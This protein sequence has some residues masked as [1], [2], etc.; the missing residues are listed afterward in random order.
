ML[1]EKKDAINH[2]RD[3]VDATYFQ[4]PESFGGSTVARASFTG[5]HGERT[6]G[7]N[8]TRAYYIINGSAK[9]LLDGEEAVASEGD[10]M[11]IKPKQTYNLWPVGEKVDVL[12]ISE[13]LDLSNLPK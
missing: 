1:I 8:I 11:V 7:E 12:L 6:L 5:E 4:L 9:F 3:G 10:L 2:S 13:L